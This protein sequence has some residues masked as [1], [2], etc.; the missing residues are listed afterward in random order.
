MKGSPPERFQRWSSGRH[1]LGEDK[2]FGP[3]PFLN[4]LNLDRFGFSLYR[5]LAEV[6]HHFFCHHRLILQYEV[7]GDFTNMSTCDQ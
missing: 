1:K 3:S 2:R 6:G 7:I 4:G 5:L